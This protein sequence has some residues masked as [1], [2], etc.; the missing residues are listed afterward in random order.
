MRFLSVADMPRD[1]DS[2][3]AGTVAQTAVALQRRGHEVVELWAEDVG[4]RITHGNLHYVIEAPTALLRAVRAKLSRTHFDVVLLSQP[5]G[6]KAARWIR[7]NCPNTV[8]INWSHG[9]E[10]NVE[11][12]LSL[13][14]QALATP[15]RRGPRAALGAL[16]AAR[17]D[18]HATYMVNA[19]D[20]IVVGAQA[21]KEF[22]VARHGLDSARIRVVPQAPPDAYRQAPLRPKAGAEKLGML[23]VGTPSFFKG[24]PTALEVVRTLRAQGAEIDCS[25]VT[26]RDG[27]ARLVQPSDRDVLDRIRWIPHLQQ[28]ELM[29]VYDAHDILLFPSY[30]EGFG[31]AF[32]EAMSRGLCVVASNAGGMRDVITDGRDGLLCPAGRADAF[33][34][35]ICR[36]AEDGE[37]RSLLGANARDTA[38]RYSWDRVA[39]EVEIFCRE[40]LAAKTARDALHEGP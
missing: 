18:L 27:I 39:R 12:V 7:A 36:L 3:A 26:D 20:G 5:H 19:C 10:Q 40:R 32:L 28:D 21:C 8:F 16:L 17:L 1:L 30:F 22:I 4:R 37:L 33:V 23:Q 35:A 24:I 11:T 15:R 29:D 9:W 13:H 2:G 34:A 14:R 6:Y 25:W 38:L 31:K